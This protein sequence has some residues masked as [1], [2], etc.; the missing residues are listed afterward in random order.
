MSWLVLFYVLELGYIP[1]D[2]QSPVKNMEYTSLYAGVLMWNVLEVSGGIKTYMDGRKFGPKNNFGFIPLRDT[3]D[4]NVRA[5][6][7]KHFLVGF[8]HECSHADAPGGRVSSWPGDY[9]FQSFW[10][11]FLGNSDISGQ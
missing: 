3:F 5:H 8:T 6:F 11:R 9:G 4:V 1:M 10:I 2:A 7:G